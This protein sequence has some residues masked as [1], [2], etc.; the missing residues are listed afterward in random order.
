MSERLDATLAALRAR[1][2]G[3]FMPFLVI[4][5]P[6]LATCH[7][8]TD[9]LAAAESD[10][11]EFGFPF[12]D[13]PADGPVIQ[14]A[15]SRALAAGVTPPIAF[16]F[17]AAVRD[18][19]PQP[20]VL[21]LYYNLVLQ[22]GVDAFYARAAAV[23]VDGILIADLPI[24]HADEATTAA[25]RHGIAPIFI[26]T[27]VSTDERLARLGRVGGGFLYTVARTGVTGEQAELDATLPA[28]LARLRAQVDLPLLCG[29]G[30]SQPDQVRAVIAAGAQGAIVGSALVR[31]IARN[32]SDPDAAVAAVGDLA[33][34]LK[35]ATR[36]APTC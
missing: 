30:I 31:Q 27:S 23:G 9:A 25:R 2:E 17:L 13:P 5:D 34:Q 35:V 20:I 4:G 22:Y 36:G 15:D 33:H 6:D 12:S 28:T 29:F 18:R 24:E 26:G 21:L 1:G 10:I 14:A 8:L 7:R 32:L 16:D 19:H 11:L 3:A